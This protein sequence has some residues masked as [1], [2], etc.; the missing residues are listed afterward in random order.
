MKTPTF[1]EFM[2]MD[3]NGIE[4]FYL[5]LQEMELGEDN[6]DSWMEGWSDLRKLVDERYARLQLATE[7]DTADIKAEKNY[8]DFLEKIYPSVRTADQM[9]KEK[10]LISDLVPTGM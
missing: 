4:P 7:L 10:I 1:K 8:H 2:K 5:D 9:L 6:L 3:W